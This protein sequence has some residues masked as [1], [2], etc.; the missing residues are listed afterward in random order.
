MAFLSLAPTLAG[1]RRVL[2]VL[3][4]LGSL[5][6]LS[7]RAQAT[8]CQFVLGFQTLHDLDAADVG[9]CV[10]NQS[11]AANGD[12]LQHTTRGL[13]VWRKADNWTAFTNGYM[14]WINGP[15]GLASRLNTDRFAWEAQATPTPAPTA[16]AAA[17]A[18]VPTPTPT[19]SGP[20]AT[21]PSCAYTTD[22]AANGLVISLCKGDQTFVVSVPVASGSSVS[23]SFTYEARRILGGANVLAAP[24]VLF[25]ARVPGVALYD[26]ANVGINIWDTESPGSKPRMNWTLVTPARWDPATI[27]QAYTSSYSGPVRMELF[28]YTANAVSFTFSFSGLTYAPDAAQDPTYSPLTL[29]R[30]A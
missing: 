11:F 29:T 23:Y 22:S 14:T 17:A 1:V 25:T 2:L 19:P 5:I 4:L 13:M 3:G 8:S 30:T 28:N 10:D 20:P 27:Q 12:A 18:N 7:V 21:S 15:N 16:T 26:A 6:P 24:N 9:E